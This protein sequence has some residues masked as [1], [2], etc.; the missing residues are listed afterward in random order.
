MDATGWTISLI[1]VGIALDRSATS[2][3]DEP[4]IGR[5]GLAGGVDH[6]RDAEAV[7]AGAEA[8][9][10][11]RGLEGHL[12]LTA[13]RQRLEDPVGGLGVGCRVR[14]G[15]SRLGSAVEPMSTASGRVSAACIPWSGVAPGISSAP[16]GASA[17][18]MTSSSP[19]STSW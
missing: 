4:S 5:S 9:R 1:G 19:P 13:G 3:R 16:G 18:V 11:E 7:E 2:R 8:A 14:D 6:P 15:H 17:T 10:P 12:D